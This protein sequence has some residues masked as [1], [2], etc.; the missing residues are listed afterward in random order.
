[1]IKH[2]RAKEKQNFSAH[3]ITE[4]RALTSIDAQRYYCSDKGKEG[5]FYVDEGD[6]T[7]VDDGVLVLVTAGGKRLKRTLSAVGINVENFGAV[8]D[9]VTDC[10]TAFQNGISYLEK[11]GG[12][13]LL[14]PAKSYYTS[15]TIYIKKPGISIVGQGSG[16]VQGLCSRIIYKGAD[17]AIRLTPSGQTTNAHACNLRYLKIDGESVGSKGIVLGNSTGNGNVSWLG[18]VEDVAVMNF[19]NE[20]IFI[21]GSQGG[22]LKKV[23]STENR[24]G[25]Y[26]GQEAV[27]GA[28]TNTITSLYDCRAYQNSEQGIL[29]NESQGL[30]F[31]QVLSE[32][33]GSEGLKI[34]S[35][36]GQTVTNINLQGLWTENN[37]QTVE[38]FNVN[39]VS[40]DGKPIEVTMNNANFSGLYNPY[41]HATQT[42]NRYLRI[43]GNIFADIANMWQDE[44]GLTMP[45]SVLENGCR[46]VLRDKIRSFAFFKRDSNVRIS[47][48]DRYVW[49]SDTVPADGTNHPGGSLVLPIGDSDIIKPGYPLAHIN[50]YGATNSAE[51]M[52]LGRMR[53]LRNN[54]DI[55][56]TD[57]AIAVS[58]YDDVLYIDATNTTTEALVNLPNLG[59]D[60]AY[61]K[62]K[63][64]AFT[65]VK[66]DASAKPVKINAVANTVNN[67][68]QTFSLSG[69]NDSVTVIVTEDK[70]WKIVNYGMNPLQ[71]READLVDA[72]NIYWNLSLYQNARYTMINNR[73][74]SNPTNKRPGHYTLKLVQ[75][76]TGGR[77]FTF[78][79][80]WKFLNGP[81]KIKTGANEET[82]L[83][84][85]SDGTY[86]YHLREGVQAP[87]QADSTAA[88]VA[89]IVADHN[90]LL[91]KL[92]AA[93]VIAT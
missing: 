90:A 40:T 85:Y 88:D 46:I 87:A 58:P 59:V 15:G 50:R 49:Q 93:G 86:M 61:D 4:L 81:A 20:G 32:F 7:S 39:I 64:K 77:T 11:K 48:I 62:L 16:Y 18:V 23:F 53:I 41:D 38:G 78:S 91:A 43:S 74:L 71:T 80:D 57:T 22:V 56:A 69:Q 27:V 66:V 3:S 34:E 26:F 79:S 6:T 36:L 84:F 35:I 67:H 12:G 9:G 8:G 68:S 75:D 33:N 70:K 29:I 2:Y 54:K 55:V 31:H 44:F 76:A 19:V 72:V 1:M 30:H 28:T 52:E 42:G 24:I 21:G 47:N 73:N 82:V 17:A 83:R 25:F 45:L 37:C 60:T 5:F 14:V 92:R 51:F 13:T 10:Y 65:I 89:G 63:G